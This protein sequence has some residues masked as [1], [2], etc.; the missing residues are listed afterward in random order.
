MLNRLRDQM[1]TR[2]Q[3]VILVTGIRKAISGA[4][5]P[6][7]LEL[8]QQTDIVKTAIQILI[9]ADTDDDIRIMKVTIKSIINK[10]AN[11]SRLSGF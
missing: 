11:S 8:F 1:L 4:E 10:H 3:H 9:M 2:E 5:V 7:S 6:P